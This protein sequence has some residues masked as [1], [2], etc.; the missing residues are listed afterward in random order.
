MGQGAIPSWIS[1]HSDHSAEQTVKNKKLDHRAIATDP[2]GAFETFDEKLHKLIQRRRDL[3]T[4]F[5]APVPTEDDLGRD[6]LN[7]VLETPNGSLPESERV[8]SLSRD[9]VHRLT[10]DRFE[11]LIALLEEQQGARVILTPLASDGGID[12]IAMRHRQI[13]LIQCK[14]TLWDASVD[15]EVVAELIQAFD[16]YRARWLRDHTSSWVLQAILVTNGH[17]TAG[18]RRAATERGID[19]VAGSDL[20]RL[21][22]TTPCTPAGIEAMEGRR[23]AS[24]RDVQVAFE[25]L[26]RV[27]I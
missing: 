11:A 1:R 8:G 3:A 5:L 15:A 4:E 19:L 16:G 7:D 25:S 22:E 6:L 26:A 18:A 9:E 24:L 21:L 17:Y 20:W 23:L 12:V 14:H 13:S 10:P 2:Q 27:H